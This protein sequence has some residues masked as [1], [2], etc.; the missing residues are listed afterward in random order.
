MNI[1]SSIFEAY[2]KCPTKGFLRAHGE[3]GTGNLYADWAQTESET[4][5]STVSKHLAETATPDHCV[6]GLISADDLKSAKWT[7]AVDVVAQKGNVESRIHAIERIPSEGRGKAARFIP[8]RYIFRNKLT[9]DD[10]IL[11]AFDAFVLLEM[12]GRPI[13]VGKIIHGD[14]HSTLTVKT[15]GHR[16]R[17]RKLIEKLAAMLSA[18]KAPDL[19]L[20]RHC[21]EC[22]FQTRCRQKAVEK[23]DLSLLSRLSEKERKKLNSNG[24]FTVT[25]LSYTFRPRHRPKKLRDKKEKYH[26]SLKALAI[27]EKKIHIVGSP[28]VKIEG[29][30]VYFDV[31]GLP[32]RDFY[33]LIG[34]RI[35]DGESAI[36]HSLWADTA[37]DEKKIWQHFLAI[38]NT[39]EKPVLIHYGRFETTFLKRMR[40]CY[41]GPPEESVASKTLKAPVNLLTVIFAQVYFPTYTNGLK[42]MAGFLGFNWSDAKASGIR[43]LVWRNTWDQ[44]RDP[45]VK[46]TLV[47]YNAEDCEALEIVTSALVKITRPRPQAGGEV[48]MSDDVVSVESMKRQWP[49]SFGS[50]KSSVQ[51]I[52]FLRKAAYWNYQ[53]DHVHFRDSNR[54]VRKARRVRAGC[55]TTSMRINRVVVSEVTPECPTCKRISTVPKALRERIL[56]DLHFGHFSVKRTVVKYVYQTYLCWRC[57]LI[58]GSLLSKTT[59]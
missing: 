2:L 40:D 5:R 33:Y 34:I 43:F 42:E 6:S 58:F 52:E 44:S 45:I 37:D 31:E 17:V 39:I 23:D 54:R 14:N 15:A 35:G 57:H 21:G 48:P 8:I 26:H 51:E 49:F 27:R 18:D 30:P 1:T 56:Y 25:Q 11:L 3:T 13:T 12:F 36:Q 20:I 9:T 59:V 55:M 4:Y 46:Q 41:G 16:N 19:V 24:I 22:E 7:S 32:D 28:V 50:K 38:L 29:T 47:Q 10:K 53:H